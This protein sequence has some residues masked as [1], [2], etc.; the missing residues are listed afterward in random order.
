MLVL[1]REDIR[2][3]VLQKLCNIYATF[4]SLWSKLISG[5]L[6]S[7]MACRL[8]S[9]GYCLCSLSENWTQITKSVASMC[10]SRSTCFKRTDEVQLLCCSK[11]KGIDRKKRRRQ[12]QS[13]AWNVLRGLNALHLK[14]L[15]PGIKGTAC[16]KCITHWLRNFDPDVMFWCHLMPGY[17]H[18]NLDLS[19]FHFQDLSTRDCYLSDE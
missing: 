17:S 12:F 15:E 13:H 4:L 3:S 19:K 14:V 2:D 10:N 7:G 16:Q 11:S 1:R 6:P 18:T 5:G 8:V 9:Y